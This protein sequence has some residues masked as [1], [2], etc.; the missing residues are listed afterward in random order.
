MKY[1]IVNDSGVDYAFLGDRQSWLGRT[2]VGWP[3][4]SD[5]LPGQ[6]TVE[7]PYGQAGTYTAPAEHFER[8][9]E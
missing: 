4:S 2:V 6:V 8:I 7:K 5:R 1:R 9:E 3:S